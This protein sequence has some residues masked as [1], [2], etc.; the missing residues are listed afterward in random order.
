MCGRF[1][2]AKSELELA[3][4][5]EP[6][7][8]VGKL[9]EPSY[10]IAPTQQIATLVLRP[11]GRDA[12][13]LPVAPFHRELYPARWGL[14]PKWQRQPTGAPLINARI[15]SVLE[16]PSF[17]AA[18]Q[19]RCVVPASGYFEWQTTNSSKQPFF[20][21]SA[22]SDGLINL[23]ALFEW[24]RSK[25]PA[26]AAS[27]EVERGSID[28]SWTLTVTLITTAAPSGLSEIHDRAPLIIRNE[29]L[30]GWLNPATATTESLL[31]EFKAEAAAEAAALAWYPVGRS[32]GSIRNNGPQLIER[33]TLDS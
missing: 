10:N 32:V 4:A 14:V 29:S 17:R 20:I 16:K 13:G 18:A 1:V 2:Q 24:W 23:A 30:A 31:D 22:Q 28:A 9:P 5:Y 27:V 33:A 19:R 8:I 26:A 25:S 15:E 11:E 7:A 21:T 6:E 3:V 12:A